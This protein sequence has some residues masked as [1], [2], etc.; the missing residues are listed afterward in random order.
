MKRPNK[1]FLFFSLLAVASLMLAACGPSAADQAATA[2]ADAVHA[3][4]TQAA[5]DARHA[6]ENEAA[7]P[8]FEP[9]KVEAPS[10]DYG[11]LIKSIEAVDQY[12]VKFTMCAPDP[13]MPAKAAFSAFQI[14]PSEYLEST[15]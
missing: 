10:C 15:G 12:T 3:A 9:M 8:T 6:A 11:G 5:E 13:A 2:A 14:H 1:L 4:E 7:K